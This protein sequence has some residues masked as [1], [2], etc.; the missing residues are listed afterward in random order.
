MAVF[1]PERSKRNPEKESPERRCKNVKRSEAQESQVWLS[2][3]RER[4]G[5][6]AKNLYGRGRRAAREG[7]EGMRDGMKFLREGEYVS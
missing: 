4:G 3:P 2:P 6:T 5:V 1:C 7:G